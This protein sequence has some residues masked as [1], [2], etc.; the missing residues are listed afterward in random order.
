MG[1]VHLGIMVTAVAVGLL[2]QFWP[3]GFPDGS[4]GIM[5]CVV[6]YFVLSSVLVLF[7]TYVERDYVFVSHPVSPPPLVRAVTP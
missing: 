2:G 3:E 5:G 7:Q 6:A 1:N 4:V